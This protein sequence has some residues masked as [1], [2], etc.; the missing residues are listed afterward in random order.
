MRFKEIRVAHLYFK[1]S[2]PTGGCHK[3]AAITKMKRGK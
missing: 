2:R 1:I 3:E